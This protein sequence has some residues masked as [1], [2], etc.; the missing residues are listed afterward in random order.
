MDRPDMTSSAA[1]STYHSIPQDDKLPCAVRDSAEHNTPF[2]HQTGQAW[3]IA[4]PSDVSGNKPMAATEPVHEEA[5]AEKTKTQNDAV[6]ALGG[7]MQRL[8]RELN[9]LGQVIDRRKRVS[10]A[11]V[12]AK[13]HFYSTSRY[14]M[15]APIRILLHF[16][17]FL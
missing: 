14:S 17:S 6:M 3:Q 16:F 1:Q 5:A 11:C 7:A 4:R 10:A 2:G 13:C 9:M 8:Q 12:W 15:K